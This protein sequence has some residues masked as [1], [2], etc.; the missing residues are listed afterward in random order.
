[1]PIIYNTWHVSTG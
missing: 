1:M